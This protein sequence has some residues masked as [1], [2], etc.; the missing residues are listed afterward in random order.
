MKIN[1][2]LTEA[3][4]L[5]M[6]GRVA[7]GVGKGVGKGLVN[8][9]APSA[10]DK[11]S[12]LGTQWKAT[13]SLS[14]ATAP[15][16]TIQP[17]SPI[18]LAPPG[19]IVFTIKLPSGSVSKYEDEAWRT[20]DGTVVNNPNDVR[21]L[22][23]YQQQNITDPSAQ[24]K[25]DAKKDAKIRAKIAARNQTN[26]PVDVRQ[27]PQEPIRIGKEVIKSDDPRYAKLAA[28]MNKSS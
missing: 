11:F 2:I 1:E 6:V 27:A 14:P 4:I 19:N 28:A 18:E 23:Y 24:S 7:K 8:V 26:Q 13:K 20:E 10:I 21:R 9:A 22:D 12:Q 17:I 3:G 25:I 15:E 5:S 16:P